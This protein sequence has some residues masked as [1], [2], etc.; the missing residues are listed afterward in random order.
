MGRVILPSYYDRKRCLIEPLFTCET[1]RPLDKGRALALGTL[2]A[3]GASTLPGLDPCDTRGNHPPPAAKPIAVPRPNCPA[4]SSPH[5]IS[6]LRERKVHPREPLSPG[7]SWRR[8]EAAL[9]E[10]HPTTR[11]VDRRLRNS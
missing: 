2:P 1:W 3:K 10:S 4:G 6:V 5:V 9:E 8:R 11:H 7:L